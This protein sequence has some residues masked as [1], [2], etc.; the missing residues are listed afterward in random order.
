MF[1]SVL[2]V[3]ENVYVEDLVCWKLFRDVQC[4]KTFAL[5]YKKNKKNKKIK[6]RRRKVIYQ[7]LRCEGV[8]GVLHA[9]YYLRYYEDG[10]QPNLL[11]WIYS[12]GTL[13][14]CAPST[15]NQTPLSQLI[16]ILSQL[17]LPIYTRLL[18]PVATLP[19]TRLYECRECEA[20]KGNA[21]PGVGSQH[22]PLA[23]PGL[24]S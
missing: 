11:G 21:T 22:A 5:L 14:Y 18:K 9:R 15:M 12:V 10:H 4:L 17:I 16:L 23:I 20:N 13:E 2:Q 7:P 8:T 1:E 6:K 3:L 19:S 24:T